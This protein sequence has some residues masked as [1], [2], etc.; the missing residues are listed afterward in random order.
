ML[1]GEVPNAPAPP[2]PVPTR[3]EGKN[4][5]PPPETSMRVP[6]EEIDEA[7]ENAPAPPDAKIVA[8]EP[9]DKSAELVPPMGAPPPD[10]ATEFELPTLHIP[11]EPPLNPK[12][13]PDMV[14]VPPD[15]AGVEVDPVVPPAPPVQVTMDPTLL[16]PP[17]VPL[18]PVLAF[19]VPAPTPPAPTVMVGSL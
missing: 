12:P 5:P 18:L 15:A 10:A 13:R 19:N 1:F 2:E 9:L 16:V 14:K 4:A 11:L 17:A 8:D 7:S 3:L 6:E